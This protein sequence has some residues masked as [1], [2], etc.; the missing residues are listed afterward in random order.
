MTEKGVYGSYELYLDGED[1]T[2]DWCYRDTEEIVAYG[3]HG[4]VY[5]R[6]SCAENAPVEVEWVQR[7]IQRGL[8]P[9]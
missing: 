7:P 5:C 3:P 4:D 9:V 1:E 2:C 6:R 8:I